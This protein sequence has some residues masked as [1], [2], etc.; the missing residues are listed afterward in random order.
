[1]RK[2]FSFDD[3]QKLGNGKFFYER[4]LTRKQIEKIFPNIDFSVA[5]NDTF[6]VAFH[7]DGRPISITD[8]RKKMIEYLELKFKAGVLAASH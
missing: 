1:M 4:I 6:F 2:T 3:F 5:E 7:A 8:N